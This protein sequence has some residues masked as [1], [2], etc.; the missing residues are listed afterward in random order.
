MNAP[1]KIDKP[2]S[3]IL[4]FDT[5][6]TGLPLFTEPSDDPRQ[7]HIV[8]IA[9]ELCSSDGVVLETYEA[10]VNPGIPIP[11]EV[12]AIHGITDEIAQSGIAEHEMLSDFF[13]L[14]DRADL[15]VGHN[16]SFDLRMI[17]IQSARVFGEK[18][19]CPKPTFCTCTEAKDIVKSPAKTRGKFKKPNL[20]ETVK[21]FFGEDLADAHTAMADTTACRR[22]YFAIKGTDVP[23]EIAPGLVVET[24]GDI[25]DR[26]DKK[27]GFD[28]FEARAEA[29]E[30]AEARARAK[31]NSNAPADPFEAHKADIDD[32]YDEAKNWL[33]G[34]PIKTQAQAD[35]VASL[36]DRLSKAW[37]AADDA[38]DTEKRPHLEAGNAVQAK[39]KPILT[40]AE[41]AKA[42]AKKAQEVWLK[43]LR[44]EQT[45]IA[46]KAAEEAEVAARTAVE[47]VQAA[48]EAGDL[49]A[50][51]QAETLVDQAKDLLQEAKVAE[52]AKPQAK[53]QFG[54]RAMG[55]RSVWTPT[56][57]D[58]VLAMRHYWLIPERRAEIEAL[59]LDMARKDVRASVRVIPGFDIKEDHIV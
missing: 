41:T 18:W 48:N 5:E 49:S 6:T 13:A 23:K 46:R 39:Y 15:V 1:A 7:P 58:G 35:D 45:A 59:M 25:L 54:A 42:V 38:R 57:T 14:V 17:R 10:V 11:P 27:S 36:V 4:V 40:K 30:E 2:P 52:K 19:E 26:A 33:D 24:V 29:K 50:R 21:H 9:A 44:D 51:E 16:V 34:E 20:T 12:S 3:L 53:S 56:L 37:K 8:Q 22:I 55:L 32:L 47:A 31:A 28:R 43:K